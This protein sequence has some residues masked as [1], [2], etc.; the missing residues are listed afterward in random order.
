MGEQLR[1]RASARDRVRGRRWLCDRLA[2]P[3]GDLLAHMLD[4]L[5]LPRDE[6]Q[7]LGHV[8]ADLAQRP[9]ATTGTDRWQRIDDAL[10]RQMLRQGPSCRLAPL[11][12]RHRNLVARRSR[13]QPGR[14]LGLRGILLQ[15]SQLKLELIQQCA[16]FR[17][18]AEPLVLQ[19]PDCVF[20][21]LD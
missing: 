20:E 1:A 3:A 16:T 6:L 9:A 8:L 7:R 17:G 5:P 14:H 18:L 2:G 21:L 19:L 12:R 11:K 13:Y 15:I 4:H 10:A